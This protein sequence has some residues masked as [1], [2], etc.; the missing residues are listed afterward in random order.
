MEESPEQEPGANRQSLPAGPSSFRIHHPFNH[1]P[2][3]IAQQ[4]QGYDQEQQPSIRDM[5]HLSERALGV[6]DLA[7]RP[8]GRL[9]SEISDGDV[10]Q[11]L[12][13]VAHPGKPFDPGGHVSRGIGHA[14]KSR[15]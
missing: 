5:V 4:S 3:G 15:V 10:E 13:G 14:G 9:R 8:H 1:P 2:Q 6:G 12:G 11:R 7:A